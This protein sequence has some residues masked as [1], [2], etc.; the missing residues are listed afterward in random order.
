MC[1]R[2]RGRRLAHILL[3]LGLLVV[4]LLSMTPLAAQAALP[5]NQPPTPGAWQPQV[6][7][8]VK[9]D[10]SAPLR[11][12]SLT[13]QTSHKLAEQPRHPLPKAEAGAKNRAAV[14]DAALQL[15]P[16]AGG[17][18]PGPL[19]SFEGVGNVN[20]LL[21]PDTNGDVGPNHYV[22]FVNVSFAVFSKSGD[23]LFGPANEATL[24]QGF[25]TGCEQYDS[26]DPIAL[27]LS[28]IHISE[29]TRTY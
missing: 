12:L 13:T 4:V 2:D 21:P 9:N 6:L 8:S 7:L 11:E 18:L 5:P 28:L 20:S 22:Q 14:A 19:R 3:A 15:D 17:H 1:I 24:F 10:T 25:G 26:G 23:L 16:A 27:Y 29:P